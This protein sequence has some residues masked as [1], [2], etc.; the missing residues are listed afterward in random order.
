MDISDMKVYFS[1]SSF[2]NDS[3]EPIV[4]KVVDPIK[5][6]EGAAYTVIGQL[7]PEETVNLCGKYEYQ[8]TFVDP[9]GNR[10]I[11]KG[12]CFIGSNSNRNIDSFRD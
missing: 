10:F 5:N 11:G 1:L 12:F 3:T 7:T 8:F 4:S 2:L 6:D 9:S